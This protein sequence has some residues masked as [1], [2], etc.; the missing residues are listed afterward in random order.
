VAR[1]FWPTLYTIPTELCFTSVTYL[2]SFCLL[3]LDLRTSEWTASEYVTN[4]W[5]YGVILIFRDWILRLVPPF[6]GHKEIT[7]FC[8]KYETY[9]N[10]KI[11]FQKRDNRIAL[12]FGEK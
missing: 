5:R 7:P 12:H 1:F 8:Q 9:E 4:S 6:W 10:G 2:F 3:A 11:F